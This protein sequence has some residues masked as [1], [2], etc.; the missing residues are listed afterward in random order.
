MPHLTISPHSDLFRQSE[1]RSDER[2]VARWWASPEARRVQVD[3]QGRFQILP[4]EGPFDPSRHYLLGTSRPDPSAVATGPQAS[5]GPN[6]GWWFAERVDEVDGQ[7]AREAESDTLVGD[8]VLTAAAVLAWHDSSPHCME[9]G[10][11]TH[12]VNG[13][14]IRECDLCGEPL[15]PRQD[16]AVIVAVLDS[17]DRLLLAHARAWPK[18]RYSVLAGFIEAGESL[19]HTV[20]REVFEEAG[21]RVLQARYVTSQ[22]WPFPRSLMIGFVA[23]V[24]DAEPEPDG[25]EIELAAFYRREDVQ[26]ALAEGSMSIPG[27]HTTGGRLIRAW[28]SGELGQAD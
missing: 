2:T 9:C 15:F 14:F 24:E 10:G 23:S 7:S 3:G 28:M 17:S 12:P 19:E 27:E 20:G 1:Q 25:D 26:Q 5:T 16:P 11:T 21:L 18:G 8:V 4:T 6:F 13:G 22:P